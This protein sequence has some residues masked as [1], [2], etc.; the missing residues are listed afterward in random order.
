M[1]PYITLTSRG[2]AEIIVNKSRF[3]G[4][5]SPVLTEEEALALLSEIRGARKD[6]SHNVYA[7][8]VG[9]NSGIMR[10]SDDGEPQG[11]AGV[12]VLEVFKQRKIVNAAVVVTR[13]F[14]GVLLGAGGLV[15][16]YSAA[17]AAAV[18]AAGVTQMH[19]S[20][21]LL[22]SVDYA[23][24]GRLERALSSAP[25][26]VQDKAFAADITLT[27]LTKYADTEEVVRIITTSTD[28]RAQAL[29]SDDIVYR[30]WPEVK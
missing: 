28:G 1:Q 27:L 29:V 22:V 17:C 15:R 30:P 24:L 11:T 4:V 26:V 9:Q 23:L 25:C 10:Y 14:G 3:V 2:E 7:Y 19:P 21:S 18:E 20:A 16:A 12:P 13:W 5:A 6:A 8:I